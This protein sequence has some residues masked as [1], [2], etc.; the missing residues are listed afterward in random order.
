MNAIIDYN[1]LENSNNE[2]YDAYIHDIDE[3]NVQSTLNVFREYES[4]LPHEEVE[5]NPEKYIDYKGS[6]LLPW[7]VEEVNTRKGGSSSSDDLD[8][9]QKEID[10]LKELLEKQS[11]LLEELTNNKK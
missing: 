3:N 11:K 9:M 6:L 2:Y 1:I 7:E 5:A 4:V 10:E 8:K